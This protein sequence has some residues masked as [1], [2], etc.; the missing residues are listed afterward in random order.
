MMK[1]KPM[2]LW[3]EKSATLP[4]KIRNVVIIF[5]AL[6]NAEEKWPRLLVTLPPNSKLL[7]SFPASVLLMLITAAWPVRNMETPLKRYP[8]LDLNQLRNSSIA[9]SK[10]LRLCKLAEDIL[11]KLLEM[12]IEL[13]RDLCFEELNYY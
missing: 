9:H 11:I 7:D 12:Y 10:N 6:N 1:S 5:K 3:K 13:L 8:K 4:I 2:S